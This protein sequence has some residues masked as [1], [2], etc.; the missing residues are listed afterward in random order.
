MTTRTHAADSHDLIR[1][2]GARVNNLKNVSLEIPKRRLTVFTGVSGSGK[3]SL[4]FGTIA[5]ESQRLI[6][7]TYSTF[8][9]GFMPTQGRPDVDVLDGLTTAILVD[10]QPMG[11]DPRST[12][13]TA[14][15]AN[16][17]LRILFS[18]LGKPHI[19]S[20]QAFSFNVASI[21]GAGAVTLEKGGQ[22]VK[23]RRSFSITGG[24]CPRC[25][26]RGA[27]TDIDLTQLYDDSK[28]LRE[29]A[30]TAPGYTGGGWNSRLYIESGFYD[31]D[32]PI[33]KFT[34]KELRDFLH[35]EPVRMKIAGIN[36]ATWPAGSATSTSRRWRR[37]WRRCG[38]PSTRSPRS[39]WATSRST[40]PRAPCRAARRSAPR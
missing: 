26:G 33:R 15:D 16:A 3:S 23:E 40:G 17:M 11:A 14:T 31:P 24:M 12:V 36:S 5:A 20:P 6:N 35:H 21:S 30:I 32:K 34:Q 10:Q 1:V 18:R 25:E 9:Q 29:G 39:A 28:S 2:H 8:V 7:E 22:K 13:G 38:R 37:C 19:G 27:V 4:V